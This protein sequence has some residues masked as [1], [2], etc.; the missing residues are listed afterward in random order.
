MKRLTLALSMVLLNII[1]KNVFAY[2]NSEYP[3][4]TTTGCTAICTED[5]LNFCQN[6][7]TSYVAHVLNKVYGIPFNNSYGGVTWS[8]GGNWN[9]AAKNVTGDDIN[10]D[11]NP[12]PGDVAYWEYDWTGDSTNHSDDYGHVA[13]VEKVYYDS[14]GNATNIDITEY[15]FET[16]CDFGQRI[17]IPVTNPT[18]FIHILAYNEGVTSLHYLDCYEMGNLCNNQTQEEWGW[19]VNEVW[20]N[21]RC[22]GNDCN[23]KYDLA[24]INSIAS[25]FGG[26]TPPGPGDDGSLYD[27]NNLPNLRVWSVGV[28]DSSDHELNEQK[29]NL[30]IGATYAIKVYPIAEES[31]C[32]KGV[33]SDVENVETD[34]YVKIS[35]EDSDGE[36][37]FIGRVYTRP[38]TLVEGD[39]HKETV[40]YTVPSE[41]KN[42]RVYF[43]AEVDSTEEVDETNEDDNFSYWQKEWYPAV[44]SSNSSIT[45]ELLEVVLFI[46]DGDEIEWISPP[47]ILGIQIN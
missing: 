40:Y 24:Y 38:S 14:N 19:I 12:L 43:R 9:D 25:G 1:G 31:D 5:S 36:W 26:G 47:E 11:T 33:D 46:L 44:D 45:T 10:V 4:N 42:K 7:C 30:D 28:F 18:G 16:K 17:K 27:S 37:K 6:N 13:F 39:S 32:V 3:Y 8:H 21:Y 35:L 34:I 23:S 20:N 15:N 29:S 41:A 2:D 22:E